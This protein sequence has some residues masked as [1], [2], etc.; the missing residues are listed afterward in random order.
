MGWCD[1]LKITHRLLPSHRF[2]EWADLP[3]HTGQALA[4][5][6]KADGKAIFPKLPV[7]IRQHHARW[8]SNNK[9]EQA[10]RSMG[11]DYEKTRK[12]LADSADVI[13]SDLAASRRASKKEKEPTG[14]VATPTAK[15]PRPTPLEAEAA[16][17][18]IGPSPHIQTASSNMPT[19][20]AYPILPNETSRVELLPVKP[21]Q[22]VTVPA[23]PLPVQEV[24]Q[25]GKLHQPPPQIHEGQ[26][27]VMTA[28]DV[29][30]VVQDGSAVSLP[31][32][33]T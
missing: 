8:Q 31:H 24:V 13:W 23:Y 16:V 21:L 18:A 4:F 32:K 6:K 11:G 10:L 15:Q 2:V 12:T 1:G 30:F 27:T 25:G 17:A 3:A 29:S 20:T 26:R 5:T 7:Y 9:A 14:D 28:A 19:A 33:K 22:R